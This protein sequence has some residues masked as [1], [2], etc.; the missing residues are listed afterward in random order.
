MMINKTPY[1]LEHDEDKED[2]SSLEESE[3]IAD[4]DDYE[5]GKKFCS[6]LV[7]SISV[8]QQRSEV[9]SSINKYVYHARTYIVNSQ[10]AYKASTRPFCNARLI[11]EADKA[12]LDF[13]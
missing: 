12:H 10:H 5:T 8:A 1:F 3:G 13:L 7:L 2:E 9:L 11:I 6:K 4:E